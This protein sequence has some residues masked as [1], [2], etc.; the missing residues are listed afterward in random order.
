[1][2][3]FE[4]LWGIERIFDWPL[5]FCLNIC[6]FWELLGNCLCSPSTCLENWFASLYSHSRPKAVGYQGLD[7]TTV[8]FCSPHA[9]E[10]SSLRTEGMFSVRLFCN[11][12]RLI[13]Q[14]RV[15]PRCAALCGKR[16]YYLSSVII[17]STTVCS[18]TQ[19]SGS[20][21]NPEEWQLTFTRRNHESSRS[22]S[23]LKR[24]SFKSGI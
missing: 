15:V 6:G 3:R 19:Y 22:T 24:T 13:S 8:R 21:E 20:Q 4:R 2:M 10:L 5:E 18:G 17:K 1:M 14:V 11:D 9:L 16:D 23:K 12:C 7:R